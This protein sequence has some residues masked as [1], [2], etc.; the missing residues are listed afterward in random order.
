MGPKRRPDSVRIVRPGPWNSVLRIRL[1]SLKYRPENLSRHSEFGPEKTKRHGEIRASFASVRL[2]RS[3]VVVARFARPATAAGCFTTLSSRDSGLFARE[4]VRGSFLVGGAPTFRR[5]CALRLRIH[6]RES[7]GSLA[8][9]TAGIAC[10]RS[11]L[12]SRPADRSTAASHSAAAH[13]SF[14]HPVPFVVG[15]VCH[16]PSPAAIFEFVSHGPVEIHPASDGISVRGPRLGEVILMRKRQPQFSG[17]DELPASPGRDCGFLPFSH[18]CE[19]Y[20][21]RECR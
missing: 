9:H 11:A 12:S 3:V 20:V 15:L 17:E 1:G 5:D 18:L 8:T 16:Y 7:A 19:A 10:L 4:F 6:R 14:V 21:K 13:A 2:R